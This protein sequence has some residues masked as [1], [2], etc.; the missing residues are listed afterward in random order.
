MT[1]LFR[2]GFPTLVPTDA[3]ITWV[4]PFAT[5]GLAGVTRTVL[6]RF[7]ST[8]S[9]TFTLMCSVDTLIVDA[10]ATSALIRPPLVIDAT[11]GLLLEYAIGA[12]MILPLTLNA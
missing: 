9:G 10:P 1:V 6:E 2:A 4:V 8:M 12:A 11:V 5:T 7:P 3:A